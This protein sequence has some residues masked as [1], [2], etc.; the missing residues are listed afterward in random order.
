[1][2]KWAFFRMRFDRREE[3]ARATRR[4][5][6]RY[7]A[8]HMSMHSTGPPAAGAQTAGRAGWLAPVF[9]AALL[10]GSPRL[11]SWYTADKSFEK[12]FDSRRTR[13]CLFL[14]GG[15]TQEANTGSSLASQHKYP[16]LLRNTSWMDA[17][18]SSTLCMRNGCAWPGKA[19]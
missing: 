3:G 2:L 6:P 12:C 15:Q 7:L 10:C 4:V 16:F 18:A 17:E 8:P 14:M 19:F 13:V 11:L 9:V 5:P 1:M